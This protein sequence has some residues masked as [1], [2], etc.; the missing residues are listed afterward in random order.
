MADTYYAINWMTAIPTIA[1]KLN[2]IFISKYLHGKF[3]STEYKGHITM[4]TLWNTSVIS[5]TTATVLLNLPP[6]W[7]NRSKRCMYAAS[8]K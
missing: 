7:M 2:Y 4:T 3:Y 8:Y 6:S 5:I 1:N